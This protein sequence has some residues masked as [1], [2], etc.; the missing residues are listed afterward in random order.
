MENHRTAKLKSSGLSGFFPTRFLL[1]VLTVSILTNLVFVVRM[2]YPDLWQGLLVALVPPPK[3]RPTDHI[4]GDQNA[5]ITVIEYADFQCPFCAEF[6][7]SM[8]TLLKETK[9]TW[10]YRHFPIERNHPL[11]WRAA[12]A[13]ECAGEQRHFWEYADALFDKQKDLA[14]KALAEIATAVGLD[15]SGFGKCLISQKFRSVILT[16]YNDGVGRKITGTP[17]FYVNRKRFVGSVP[18]EDL[19]RIVKYADQ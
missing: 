14:E 1:T 19:K 9:V 5:K 7:T 15:S 6:H 16:D 8:R 13:S 18:Y 4:R 11:A 2:N 10:V 12:E 17:T 3:V